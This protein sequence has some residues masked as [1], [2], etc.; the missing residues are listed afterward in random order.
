[1]RSHSVMLMDGGDAD[2]QTVTIDVKAMDIGQGFEII[3][4][5]DIPSV[6]NTIDSQI[7]SPFAAS[8]DTDRD[9]PEVRPTLATFL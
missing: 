8:T 6:L 7:P 1:M 9:D 2:P 5:S 3:Y 4:Y